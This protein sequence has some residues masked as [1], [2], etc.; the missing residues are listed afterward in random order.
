LVVVV[1]EL[2]AVKALWGLLVPEALA[3]VAVPTPK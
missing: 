3:V 1:A 2:L